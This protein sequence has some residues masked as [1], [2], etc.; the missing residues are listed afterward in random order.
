MSKNR[1]THVLEDLEI[2]EASLVDKGDNPE[3]HVVLAKNK[4]DGEEL[5]DEEK[6]LFKRFLNWFKKE[7]EAENESLSEP[8]EVVEEDTN[9][10]PQGENTENSMKTF[11]DVLE[12]LPEEER[13]L[14]TAKMAASA[15]DDVS[16]RFESLE[17]RAAEAEAKVAKMEEEKRVAACKAKAAELAISGVDV[18]ALAEV[19]GDVSDETGDKLGKILAAVKEQADTSKL[20]EETGSDAPS[21]DSAAARLEKIAAEIQKRDGVS[22]A[23]AFDRA[24]QENRDIYKKSREEG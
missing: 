5:S 2:N 7:A 6:S 15:T 12:S 11:D 4:A 13:A 1:A 10:S 22:A 19:F 3:A 17:K 14:I 23:V 21:E 24:C 18:D 9:Q 20:F 16:K 8:T